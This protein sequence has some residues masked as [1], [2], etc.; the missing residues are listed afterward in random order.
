[1]Q[2]L[3]YMPTVIQAIAD[4]RDRA[5]MEALYNRHYLFMYKLA[6]SVLKE[7]ESADDIVSESCVRLIQ[8]IAT[9]MSLDSE[10][11][12]AY[13]ANTVRTTAIDHYRKQARMGEVAAHSLEEAQNLFDPRMDVERKIAL[14]SELL[15]T[16]GAIKRLPEREQQVMEL[17]FRFDMTDAEIAEALGL[18]VKSIPKYVSRARKHLK[19]ILYAEE[20]AS[21]E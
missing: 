18:S 10:G 2:K 3:I 11:L 9:L 7:A 4:D 17:K 15:N 5:F 13:I 6:W 14:E 20:E 16:L 8:N 12:E 19:E 21:H 1:M